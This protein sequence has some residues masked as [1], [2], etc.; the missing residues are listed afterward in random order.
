[1]APRIRDGG[2]VDVVDTV[3]HFDTVD[4]GGRAPARYGASML[5]VVNKLDQIPPQ[6]REG[7]VQRVESRVRNAIHAPT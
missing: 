2:V 3:R 4:C 5:V 1:M 7:T 6:D